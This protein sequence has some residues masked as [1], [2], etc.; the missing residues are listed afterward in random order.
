[1]KILST[2]LYL[3]LILVAT[4]LPSLGAEAPAIAPPDENI[5]IKADTMTQGPAAG[6][7]T[8]SGNVLMTW[9]GL[10]LAAD[11]ARYDNTTHVL[12][13]DG[14]VVLTKGKDVMKGESFTMNLESGRGEMDKAVIS[15]PASN[16]SVT[17]EKIVRLNES[18]YEATEAE[19]TTCDLP[20]PSWKFGTSALKVN[21]A[22]YATGRNIIFYIKDIPVLYF[23]WIAFPASREKKSGLLFPRF[24][25]S[26]S[27]GYQMSI[28]LYLVI[29]P[30][31]DVQID[32][33]LMSKR[34]AGAGLD[35]RYIRARGS[36]GRFGGYL[37]HDQSLN[38]W[39][40]Q[41]GES[42]RE[43][44]S[45]D[46]NLRL[47]ISYTTDRTFM[48]DF[49]EK[50]G[51][52]NRQASNSLI[53][54]LKTWQHYAAAGYLSMTDDLYA[55]DNRAT[56]Q[57]LP[58][59]EVAGVRQPVFKTPL[60]FDI[61]ASVANLY[62]ETA[63]SGQRAHLFPRLT[64]QR[65]LDGYLHA[66]LFAGV[67][68]RGYATDKRDVNSPVKSSDGD[69]L[70]EAGARISTSLTRVYDAGGDVLKKIRH[71]IVP[72]VSYSYLPERSQEHLPFYDYTDRMVWQNMLGFS[73]T[74]L[75]NGKFVSGE[76]S[77]YREIS[78]QKLSLGYS[79][80]GGRRDLLTLV[81]TQ[82]SWSDLILESDTW[83]NRNMRLTF[84][85]RYNLYDKRLSTLALGVDADDRKGN[86]IGAGY[87]MAR[88]L[89]E[90]LEGHLSTK[91]L[92]P[93]NLSYAA[94]YSFDRGDFL[95]SVYSVEYRHKCWS[96]NVAIHQRPDNQSYSFGF[97]LVGVGGI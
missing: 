72:E 97:N 87:H 54:V 63:S 58:A 1:M 75:I 31:Q 11:H 37:I 45:P 3:L 90:Y 80:E 94:R 59:L 56:L 78:R 15:V 93:F 42:H 25:Q 81:D 53:N 16:L 44:F 17:G 57:T 46:M 30:S 40:G 10:S 8:A 95:D 39:R 65:S 19:L 5:H 62:R 71:E 92:K 70:P 77:E 89:V 83:L 82:N 24:A 27:R 26:S 14:H 28:P 43:I 67:H 23:P 64:F 41:I 50:S 96:I 55:K 60:Y 69:L 85:S 7:V 32:L 48:T 49:G 76:T 33:D 4:A 9:Q 13:A 91:L 36:E 51:D 88:A 38:L 66:S 52:Y 18:Q 61:D 6:E 20:D 86:S 2:L 34:G 22:G 79:I 84:D 73:V 29:S 35:Y 68:V 12:F 74:S 21:T 47:D